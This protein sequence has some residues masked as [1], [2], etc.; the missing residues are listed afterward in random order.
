MV[1][2]FLNGDLYYKSKAPGGE[3][4]IIYDRIS[5][6]NNPKTLPSSYLRVPSPNTQT[7]APY[8]IP[9]HNQ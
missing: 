7:P 4:T 1:I 5:F 2:V 6:P 8:D 9:A 3:T